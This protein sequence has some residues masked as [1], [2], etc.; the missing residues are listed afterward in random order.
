MR[1]LHTADLHIGKVVNEFSM[2]KEQEAALDQICSYA[3]SYQVSAVILAG[4]LYDRSIPP[5]EAVS[6]MDAFLTRLA[7]LNICVMGIAGNHDSPERISFASQILAGRGLYLSGTAQ[8]EL[9]MTELKDEYGAVRV[10]LLPFSRPA[11]KKELYGED[12]PDFEA[13]VLAALLHNP[14]EP[15]LRNV[16]VAHEFVTSKGADP[17]LSDSEV[18]VS[19]GGSDRV[20]TSVFDGFDYVALG[21]LHGPQKMGRDTIRYAGSPLKY[22]LSETGHHKSFAVVTLEEK[23]TVGVELVPFR[24]SRDLRRIKGELPELIAAG[25]T[26]PRREDYVWAVL[27]GEPVLDPAARL[28]RVYPN[29]LHVQAEG[30]PGTGEPL[31]GTGEAV[32]RA[33]EEELFASFFESVCGRGMDPGQEKAAASVFARLREHPH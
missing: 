6:L 1:F 25:E 11:V 7:D 26:D 16:L 15:S 22:S 30:A 24:P 3:A 8:K 5:A 19:V 32:P 13:G 27:T 12:M 31:P 33:T 29:L 18:R 14:P 2:L 10:Y 20:D 21:H 23:G 4:D 17:V 9:C 28:R